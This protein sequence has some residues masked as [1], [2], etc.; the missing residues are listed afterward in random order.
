MKKKAKS[1]DVLV[2]FSILGLCTVALVTLASCGAQTGSMDGVEIYVSTSGNSDS[3]SLYSDPQN[4]KIAFTKLWFPTDTA[5]EWLK[6]ANSLHD[7]GQ[8]F[9]TATTEFSELDFYK[10]LTRTTDDPYIFDA[11][12]SEPFTPTVVPGYNR[13]FHGV[14]METVYFEMEMADFSIRWYTQDSGNYKAQDVLINDGNGWK[15]A[16][17]RR[18]IEFD[19]RN[20]RIE[21][22]K[23]ENVST[24][25][26]LLVTRDTR[27][28]GNQY[29]ENWYV[30]GSITDNNGYVWEALGI[31]EDDEGSTLRQNYLDDGT[32]LT[33]LSLT[34]YFRVACDVPNDANPTFTYIGQELKDG[35]WSDTGGLTPY[36]ELIAGYD[37]DSYDSPNEIWTFPEDANEAQLYRIEIYFDVTSE[38]G[39]TGGLG[40]DSINDS[41]AA[42]ST[43]TQI[44]SYVSANDDFISLRPITGGKETR[45]GWLDFEGVWQG[46]FSEETGE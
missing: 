20:S 41:L 29:F 8:I 18:T 16:F 6:N 36:P 40:V 12:S 7:G 10:A 22:N 33:D 27:E 3:R 19:F 17:I 32:D 37:E 2:I 15:F 11:S 45:F 1:F 34:Q 21:D 39:I 24:T 26:I 5:F 23:V 43:W 42:D 30:N 35:Y 25:D 14:L 31:Y 9:I 44:V 38:N 46:E 28:A 4:V 13:T